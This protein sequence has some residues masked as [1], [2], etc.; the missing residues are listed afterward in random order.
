MEIELGQIIGIVTKQCNRYWKLYVLEGRFK[1]G[2]ETYKTTIDTVNIKL[3]DDCQV[4]LSKEYIGSIIK[5]SIVDE[6][7]TGANYSIKNTGTG[8]EVD[9]IN[10]IKNE[11]SLDY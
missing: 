5:C 11:L 3:C 4:D 7:I 2:K 1:D 9:M 6:Y 10:I 8:Y